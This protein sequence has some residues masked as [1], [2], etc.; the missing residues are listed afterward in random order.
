MPSPLPAILDTNAGGELRRRL[1]A[2]IGEGQSLVI[3]GSAVE[4]AGLACLQ[5]LAAARIAADAAGLDFRIAAPSD[6]L[7]A[8]IA[9]AGLGPALALA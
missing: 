9:L 3:D 6:S 2:A 7:K 1:R 5:V 4:Q 8:M